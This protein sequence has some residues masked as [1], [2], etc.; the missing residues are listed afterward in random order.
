ME[1]ARFLEAVERAPG[2]EEQIVH[3]EHLSAREA[4]RAKLEHAL[5]EPLQE[6]L[7]GLGIAELYTH[8]AQCV[9]VA[10][11]GRNVAVVTSTVFE[12]QAGT[13]SRTR[14]FCSTWL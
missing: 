12:A 5:P 6:A 9:E 10:R 8:Q 2:Y 4:R 3:V 1:A 14:R 7:R 13:R 11:S